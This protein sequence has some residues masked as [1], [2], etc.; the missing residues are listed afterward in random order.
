MYSNTNKR[1][2]K[3]DPIHLGYY[4]KRIV[5][6]RNIKLKDLRMYFRCSA[7]KLI[8]MFESPHLKTDELLKWSVFLDLNLF[9]LFDKEFLRL[10]EEYKLRLIKEVEEDPLLE[11]YEE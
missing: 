10:N 1:R 8:S 4:L 9:R 2:K 6:E 3:T 5:N 7:S 11:I